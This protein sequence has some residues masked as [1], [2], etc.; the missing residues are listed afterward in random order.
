MRPR[1]KTISTFALLSGTAIAGLLL[2]AEGVA[3][4]APTASKGAAKP[5][6]GTK[7][8]PPTKPRPTAEA[9][10]APATPPVAVPRPLAEEAAHVK[11]YDEA[12][13]ASRDHTLSSAD[14]GNLRDAMNAA[15]SGKLGEAN[16][17]RDKITDPAAR[18]LVDWFVYRGGYGT[19]SDIRAFL[20]ANPAWPDRSL[21]TRRAEEALFNSPGVA[22]E[23]KAFFANAEPRTAAGYAALASAYLADKDEAKARSL[24]Q[25]AWTELDIP[26]GLEAAF[27]KR[28]AGLLT[29]ADHKRRLDRL[30]SDDSRWAGERS[31]R[32]V[33]I[34]RVIALLPE[35]E[36]KKAEAR[37][38]VFLRAKNSG[39][40]IAKLPPH[41]Q[42]DWGLAVQKA[43]ALRRQKKEEEAWK[44]LLADPGLPGQI[45]DGWWEER[46]ANAYAALR[47]HQPKMAYELVRSP[48]PLSVNA[49]KDAAFLAGWLALRHLHDPKLALAHF[50]RL[51]E[52][53]DGPLS[54]A[55]GNYWL[56][57]NY[58][59]L[60]DKG[61]AQDHYKRGAGY[62]DTFHGQLCRQK[63][64]ASAHELRI[65]AP[66]AP[67]P[68]E[69]ARFNGTDAVLA[70]VVARKAGLDV[71][72]PRA[73]LHHLR[74]Y[75]KSEAEVAMVAHLAE[76]LGDTQTSVRIGKAGIARGFNLIYYAYPVHS[77]P[78]YTPLRKPPEPA[79]ILG[80][81]RQES[82]FNSLTLSGAGARGILQVMPVTAQHVCRD[83]KI[84]CDIPRLMKDPAY[85]TMLGS[86]Y[87]SDR[88]DEFS[89]S[90]ILTLAG[91]NAGP[92]RAREWIK[93]FGDPRD[94]KVDPVDWIHR[95]P[96][97]ETREYVQK[98]L[99]NIQIYRARLGDQA[100]A[101]RINADLKRVSAAPAAR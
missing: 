15:G 82:E 55:R 25:K 17:I 23:A 54:Y 88:M 56:G 74:A 46:R 34:K 70:A 85:N 97:E 31:E 35:E 84:K 19:A 78:T 40:L 2:A 8:T 38:A 10:P 50:Q 75:M 33:V 62:I 67:T 21:L 90:Y 81:A 99:S 4:T 6:P 22:R 9:S 7:A 72:V 20:D 5:K 57:R 45:P 37:L 26:S 86:A 71:S 93:E 51:A 73:F 95:I 14:A 36:K 18:K 66:A 101:L 42:M 87:I 76:A 39:Q 47:K 49:A 77:L 43:Q 68:E 13:A 79:V 94:A 53:A 32:A 30:L 59:A 44:I 12:I 64:D 65:T 96:F 60:G 29:E 52:L 41:S 80:I 24:A 11:R 100:T 91:Y 69:I 89:G 98:V 3:Q 28:M 58:E 63:V 48:G 83:Y 1:S 27:L 16:A 92:G 61:K